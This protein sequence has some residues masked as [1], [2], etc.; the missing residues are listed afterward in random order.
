LSPIPGGLFS[1]RTT[2][3]PDRR[4]GPGGGGRS[5]SFDPE[6]LD[7]EP[8]PLSGWLL[9]DR[10]RKLAERDRRRRVRSTDAVKTL[11][12]NPKRA[13]LVAH[14]CT[15]GRAYYLPV[16]SATQLLADSAATPEG[17]RALRSADAMLL[18]RQTPGRGVA[19]VR[20][21]PS[22]WELELSGG[23]PTEPGTES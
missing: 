11:A 9:G 20:V 6:G 22:P 18:P 2:L 23:P 8:R 10:T 15:L 4:A 13:R 1:G 21:V 12:E 16:R 14:L 17:E 7:A 3:R 5:T 19:R